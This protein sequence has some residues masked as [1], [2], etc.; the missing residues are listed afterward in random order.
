ML[1]PLASAPVFVETQWFYR[2][3]WWLMLGATALTLV[4][5]LFALNKPRGLKAAAVAGPL[6]LLVVA[7]LWLIRLRVRVDEVG[8]HYLF[9]PFL[10]RWRHWPWSDFRQVQPRT[11]SPL[12]DYGGW[13]IKGWPGNLAYN[14][15]GEAGLQL[16][17]QSGSRLLLGTQQP[18]ELRLVLAALHQADPTLPIIV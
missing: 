11:Y 17:F 18:E 13:G 12:G 5:L 14:V 16:V 1:S 7:G 6:V 15:W 8:I 10:N 4:P 9:T 3:W 2:R